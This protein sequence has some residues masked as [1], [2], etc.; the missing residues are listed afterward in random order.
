MQSSHLLVESNKFTLK[1]KVFQLHQNLSHSVII[2]SQLISFKY[3]F[4]CYK[5]TFI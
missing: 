3:S 2:L 1:A 4:K 5:V